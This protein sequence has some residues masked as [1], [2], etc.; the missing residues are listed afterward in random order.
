MSLAGRLSAFLLAALAV[1]LAGFSGA[2]Y[3]LASSYLYEQLDARLGTAL[4]TL[5]AAL[6]VES[7]GMEWEPDERRITLGIDPGVEQV[8]WAIRTPLGT[9]VD[10]SANTSGSGFG[11][12]AGLALVLPDVG[13]ASAFANVP[14]WR[15]AG[16][17]LRL[18][19]L[20]QAG[21][22][23]PEDDAP[24]DDVEYREL[25]IMV[26]LAPDPVR[27]SLSRLAIALA[28]TS[29]CLWGSCA[30]LSRRF[31][32]HA[33][34]PLSRMARSA[35]SLDAAG[36]GWSLPAPGTSDE[37]DDLA[38]AYNGLL[39]RLREAF[40]R[41]QRFA[42]DASHQLRTP[43][44]GLLA[45]VDVALRRDRPAEEYRRVL[46]VAREEAD[47]LRRIVEALLFLA[48]SEADTPPA[49]GLDL[50]DWLPEQ[51]RRWGGHPRVGD[52]SIEGSTGQTLVVRTHPE[53][54]GQLLDILIENA[55]K[56]SEPGKPVCVNASRRGDKIAVTVEDRGS[57]MDAGDLAA[58]FEP[59]YR[60]EAARRDGKPGEGLGL[61]LAR[62]IATTLG[63]ALDATSE[64][65]IGSRFRLLLPAEA[66]R[67]A[68]TDS[69]CVGSSR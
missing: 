51:G 55:F 34:E 14:G 15:L 28:G 40:D 39:S 61:P 47:R 22:G 2:T 57:G 42:G 64:P 27:A 1:T 4:D 36:T 29:V 16:R 44:A 13:D 50:A 37:L 43:L 38:A 19:D 58:A 35:R 25:E 3:A 11:D 59:F 56:Y 31:A 21:R 6:D 46:G 49:R 53:L 54:L 17:R 24:D 66:D 12:L 52:L 32:R 23:H 26:G 69:G 62:R 18:E 41:Q 67:P 45:Q 20:L 60:A 9:R 10:E 65:G 33:L 68:A 63:G 7:G 8:R 5:E 48:R 30:L